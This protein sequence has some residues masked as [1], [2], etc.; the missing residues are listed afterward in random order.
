MRTPEESVG[1]EPL[2]ATKLYLVCHE[3]DNPAP[4]RTPGGDEIPVEPQIPNQFFFCVS[5]PSFG[6]GKF[7]GVPP[8]FYRDFTPFG[9]S[10]IGMLKPI[11]VLRMPLTNLFIILTLTLITLSCTPKDMTE[12]TIKKDFQYGA[13]CASNLQ[14]GLWLQSSQLSPKEDLQWAWALKNQ[15]SEAQTVTIQFDDD[16][17]K[18]YRLQVFQNDTWIKDL[19]ELDL[20]P[21]KGTGMVPP[22]PAN[23]KLEVGEE[24]EVKGHAQSHGLEPGKYQCALLFGGEGFNFE[25]RSK[26]IPL[27]ISS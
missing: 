3:I 8:N 19:F 13:T 16:M 24:R 27:N 11:G 26:M 15:A 10:I 4:Y 21:M 18:R 23:I 14:V 9:G 6:R 7:G 22:I 2:G 17:R 12:K 20:K 5:T 25:C 1:R